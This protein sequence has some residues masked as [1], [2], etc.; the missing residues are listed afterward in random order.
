[1]W[2]RRRAAREQRADYW[3]TCGPV[4]SSRRDLWEELHHGDSWEGFTMV[5]RGSDFTM[6]IRERDFTMV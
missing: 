5:I 4:G 1:M 6:V 3:E 2:P